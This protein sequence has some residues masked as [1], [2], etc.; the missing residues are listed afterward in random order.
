MHQCLGSNEWAGGASNIHTHTHAHGNG[1]YMQGCRP[2]WQKEPRPDE[3]TARQLCCYRGP[4]FVNYTFFLIL[5]WNV[6]QVDLLQ[7]KT[8]AAFL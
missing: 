8:L 3:K 2:G 1:G 4:P 6:V 5:G 7:A